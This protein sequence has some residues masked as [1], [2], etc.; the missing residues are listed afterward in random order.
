M[1][2]ILTC[3]IE[4]QPDAPIDRRPDVPAWLNRAVVRSYPG[5]VRT[6]HNDFLQE[7]LGAELARPM[8]GLRAGST[9]AHLSFYLAQFLGCDP[10]ILTGQDDPSPLQRGQTIP[11][12]STRD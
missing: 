5:P 11:L 10:I 8:A 12:L 4:R 7:L 6:F 2:D 3:H 9:V 1:F